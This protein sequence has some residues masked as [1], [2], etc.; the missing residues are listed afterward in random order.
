MTL[1]KQK[2]NNRRYS[3]KIKYQRFLSHGKECTE[4]VFTSTM[5]IFPEKSID[6]EMRFLTNDLTENENN[7]KE[8]EKDE[9]L[10]REE[11]KSTEIE[12]LCTCS[13]SSKKLISK[14]SLLIDAT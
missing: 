13:Y 2:N 11:N 4:K 1:Q 7:L 5:E 6:Q 3:N 14:P 12:L 8:S 9:I 10:N